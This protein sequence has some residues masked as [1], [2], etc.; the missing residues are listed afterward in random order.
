MKANQNGLYA[1]DV[2]AAILDIAGFEFDR[3]YVVGR[4][5]YGGDHRVDFFVR[6][7]AQYEDGLVIESRWQN[8]E[9][10][11]DE[12]LPY[13]Y[14]NLHGC[15]YRSVVVIHGGACREGALAWMRE[16]CEPTHMF[17]VYRLEE[18]MAWLRTLNPSR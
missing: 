1:E 12:K 15:S 16:H 5:I 8:S 4:T 9:G 6:N 7:C 11:V 3:Q 18:F 10:S 14:L 2:L 13:M 17:A